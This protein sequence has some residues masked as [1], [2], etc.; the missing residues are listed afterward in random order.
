MY[1]VT[2]VPL[3]EDKGVRYKITIRS[4]R[5]RA[6]VEER[7]AGLVAGG[8][9]R[10]LDVG[11]M[12]GAAWTFAVEPSRPGIVVGFGKVAEFLWLLA[13]DFDVDSVERLPGE[14]SAAAC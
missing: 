8:P 14:A 2:Y 3:L 9:F 13:R 1:Y 11:H 12:G 5:T 6:G 10:V 4:I 7:L